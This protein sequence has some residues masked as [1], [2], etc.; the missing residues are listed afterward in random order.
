MQLSILVINHTKLILTMRS[1]TNTRVSKI[2]CAF[3]PLRE[4]A[5]L[6]VFLASLALCVMQLLS[7][8]VI[9]S[10]KSTPRRSLPALLELLFHSLP[11]LPAM[12][13]TP[14][15]QR[16]QNGVNSQRVVCQLIFNDHWRFR[17]NPALDESI[18]LKIF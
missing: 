4:I 5:F 13:A 1:E 10:I 12:H 11:D 7:I 9:D 16:L 18:Q 15:R 14:F 17:V 2:L 8:L 6:I 3:A